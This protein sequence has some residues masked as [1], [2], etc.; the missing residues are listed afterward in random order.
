VNERGVDA[1][2]VGEGGDVGEVDADAA[3]EREDLTPFR[4]G[5]ELLCEV[6]CE[7]ACVGGGVF[8]TSRRGRVVW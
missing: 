3:A 7:F 1:R 2:I 6:G 8:E 5:D 4:V